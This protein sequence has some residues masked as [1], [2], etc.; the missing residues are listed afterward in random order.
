LSI[1]GKGST[2][3]IDASF[4]SRSPELMEKAAT[5]RK[6]YLIPEASLVFSFVGRIVK[7]KGILELTEAF[8]RLS[9]SMDVWLLLVGPFEQE[10]DPLPD[11][12]MKFITNSNKVINAGFQEDVRPWLLASDV[13]VFPSYR[14]GFPNVV[15]QSA[16]LKVPCIVSDINGCNELIE[17]EV[18]GLIVPAKNDQALFEA[19]SLIAMDKKRCA[20]F[21]LKAHQF[22]VANYDQQYVWAELLKEY[23][24]LSIQHP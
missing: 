3:G 9:V 17:N 6:K 4:F 10:L 12:V 7:D 19:M 18:S 13:F 20:E 16:C 22:V 21:A 2:N 11:E 8:K 24:K 23:L 1:I 5:I 14:E 15:M